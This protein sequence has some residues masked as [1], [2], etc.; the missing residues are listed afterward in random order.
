MEEVREIGDE[1]RDNDGDVE[2]KTKKIWRILGG[3]DGNY[4]HNCTHCLWACVKRLRFSRARARGTSSRRRRWRVS[5]I[6]LVINLYAS[7]RTRSLVEFCYDN[8]YGVRWRPT[9][10]K[11]A[12]MSTGVNS[13]SCV[14]GGPTSGKKGDRKKS[15]RFCPEEM[16]GRAGDQRCPKS[17]PIKRNVCNSIWSSPAAVILF[18]LEEEDETDFL[19]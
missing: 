17:G 15:N 12:S 4:Y 7:I 19:L 5:P 16:Y 8:I 13:I 14:R 1:W 6:M 11:C 10:T 18:R 9:V 3:T 2:K